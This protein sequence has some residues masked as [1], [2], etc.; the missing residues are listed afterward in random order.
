[1]PTMRAIAQTEFGGPEVLREIEMPVPEALGSDLRVRVHAVGI[2]PV[3]VK[4]RSNWNGFGELQASS[5]VVTGWDAAGVV[6]A[7]GPAADGRFRVGDAVFFAGSVARQGSHREHTIVDSR[8]VGRKPAT[9]DFAEAAALPLTALTVWEGMIDHAG[10]RLDAAGPQK[11]ALVVGGA[12]GVG[13]IA[14]QLLRRVAG[15]RVV[16][17]GSRAA[18]REH[19]FAMGADAVIDHSRSLAPQLAELGIASVDHVLHT[20]EPEANFDEIAA[21]VAP[22]GRIVCILPIARPVDTSSLFARSISLVYELMFTRGLY[23]VDLARQG[24]ILDKVSALVDAGTLRTTLVDVFPWTVDGLRAAH[25]RID[26]RRGLGK[27]V[28]RVVAP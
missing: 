16:A 9:L 11:T 6:D 15:M 22:L 25:A 28:L 27:A 13:S 23:G 2:N 24:Q 18:S 20:S 4:V 14:I 26:G 10:A 1:M 19:C 17:T 7:V 12:G 21:L 3:D 5:P 8:V